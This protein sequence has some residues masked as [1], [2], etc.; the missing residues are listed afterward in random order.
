MRACSVDPGRFNILIAVGPLLVGFFSLV[1]EGPFAFWL[2]ALWPVLAGGWGG[3]DGKIV[4]AKKRKGGWR[5]PVVAV[6]EA[7]LPRIPSGWF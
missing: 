7:A 1:I 6:R 2:P 4:G 3:G 5:S